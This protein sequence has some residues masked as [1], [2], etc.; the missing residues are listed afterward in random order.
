MST[1][2]PHTRR[3]QYTRG[4][5]SGRR[6]PLAR[7]LFV[8]LVIG[9]ASRRIGAGAA[10]AGRR[11]SRR[12][13]R[14]AG[15][16]PA[17]LDEGRPIAQRRLEA[18]P[19]APAARPAVVR[20]A[21]GVG[22]RGQRRLLERLVEVGPRQRGHQDP[23]QRARALWIGLEPV[24]DDDRRLRGESRARRR[25]AAR[26]R[27]RP[28][29]AP[30]RRGAAR[31]PSPAAGAGGPARLAPRRPSCAAVTSVTRAPPS[32]S[33]WPTPS[34][35]LTRASSTSSWAAQERE[36]VPSRKVSSTSF[37]AGLS[38]G[39]SSGRRT[40]TSRAVS[41][42]TQWM[43]RASSPGAYSRRRRLPSVG[44][45]T[46][47]RGSRSWPP[48]PS[49]SRAP[50]TAGSCGSTVRLASPARTRTEWQSPNTS[51]SH[52]SSGSAR[53]SPR[54]AGPTS[55]SSSTSPPEASAS[56]T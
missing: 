6:G 56:T 34:H 53:C 24:R 50:S 21:D 33:A 14:G 12:G 2:R 17:E 48:A 22:E 55:A 3:S 11:S 54:W 41:E 19:L 49:T 23:A 13:L 35:T 4:A 9:G 38:G 36:S 29:S 20:G 10:R 51:C 37:T 15:G 40:T 47:A 31:D 42:R 46:A 5:A 44:R 45:R 30:G 28:A 27:S 1:A 32:T 7:V 43:R 52:S 25:R 39:S 16:G 8:G 18:D 26:R